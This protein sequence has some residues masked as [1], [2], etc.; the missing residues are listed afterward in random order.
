[1]QRRGW[2]KPAVALKATFVSR[3]PRRNRSICS[4]AGNISWVSPPVRILALACDV[5]R[6]RGISMRRVELYGS[7]EFFGGVRA[8]ELAQMPAGR[9]GSEILIELDKASCRKDESPQ[10][11]GVFRVTIAGVVRDRVRHA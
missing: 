5:I 3:H 4:A 1:M 6:D 2:C 9:A 10:G 7:C 11:P 8:Y